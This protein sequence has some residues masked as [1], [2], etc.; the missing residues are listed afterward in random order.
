M[1]LQEIQRRLLADYEERRNQEAL[2]IEQA[3]KDLY[4]NLPALQELESKYT[5]MNLELLRGLYESPSAGDGLEEQ[6]VQLEENF[7]KEQKELLQAAGYTRDPREKQV[8]CPI[9]KD[10][11]YTH[12]GMCLCMKQELALRIFEAEYERGKEQTSL[13][14]MD[15][16]IYSSKKEKS[17]K[18]QRSNMISIAEDLSIFVKE[19]RE[20]QGMNMLFSG[21]VSQG[22]TFLATALALELIG[23]G[24]LV[25]Y[26]T[27]PSLL[28]RLRDFSWRY[29]EDNAAMKTMVYDCDFLILDDLG[30]ETRGEFA[31]KELFHLMNMR[32]TAGKSTLISTNLSFNDIHKRYGDA[33][34]TRLMEN[35]Y[36]PEFFGPDL[37]I[38]G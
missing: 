35:C 1:T 8:Q 22:K 34:F 33:F 19:F 21:S 14:R 13:S 24:H 7:L 27:A 3:T 15:F 29:S 31:E 17:G 9:C 38:G 12:E 4:R 16:S 23:E 26:Q 11:G 25:I 30:K 6:L 36:L 32:Y 10:E 5:K 2:R 28:D 37:R 18:T 20:K